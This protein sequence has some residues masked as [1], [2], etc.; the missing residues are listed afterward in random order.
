MNW[1]GVMNLPFGTKVRLPWWGPDNY[2]YAN[3]DKDG[4]IFIYDEDNLECSRHF[5]LFQ[6]TWELWA[7]PK[8]DLTFANMYSFEE[9][10]ELTESLLKAKRILNKKMSELGEVEPDDDS[11]LDV[12]TYIDFDKRN[13]SLKKEYDDLLE[14][15]IR[16]REEKFRGKLELEK[17][18]IEKD[19]SNQTLRDFYADMEK[20]NIRLK[21]LVNLDFTVD[22]HPLNIFKEREKLREVNIILRVE[23]FKITEELEELVRVNNALKDGYFGLEDEV[24]RLRAE[25]QHSECKLKSILE[26]VESKK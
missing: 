9:L 22:G 4:A 19:Q 8:L 14:I 2:V 26:L 23:K 20:E 17:L 25:L 18:K 13:D 3:R 6:D 24:Y 15:N 5:L 11:E 7:E 21:G 1:N 16:L 10:K 12:Q